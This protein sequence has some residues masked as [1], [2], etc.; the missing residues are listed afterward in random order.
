[1]RAGNLLNRDFTAPRPNHTWVTDFTYVST[2]SGFVYTAF[3]FDVYSQMIVGWHVQ[4]SKETSLVMTCLKMA[5][6]RRGQEGH[7]IAE[8][9]IHHSDAGSQY[10]SIRFTDRLV[11]EGLT[12]SIGSVGDAYDC[13]S[14]S[15][16][17]RKN[18]V[19]LAGMV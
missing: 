5:L 2:W 1:M 13:Q 12:A 16:G 7:L 18:R 11:S 4:T 6:W 8:G 10:T 15:A 9:L 17:F 19:V 14:V 3:V